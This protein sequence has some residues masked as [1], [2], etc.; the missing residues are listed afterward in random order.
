[1]DLTDVDVRR[2]ATFDAPA[3]I[4]WHALTAEGGLAGWMGAGSHLDPHPGGQGWFADPAGGSPRRA[5]VVAV[6]DGRRLAWEWWSEDD[7]AQRSLVELTLTEDA[8][9][10]SHLAVVERPLATPT[11]QASTTAAAGGA[12]AWRLALLQVLVL[13]AALVG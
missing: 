1:M 8:P 4:V 7:P 10:R 12:W 11:L 5:R 6:E 9:G 2:E 3:E 13:T